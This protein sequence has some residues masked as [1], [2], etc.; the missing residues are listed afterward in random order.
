MNK[1]IIK[2]T[3]IQIVSAIILF[4]CFSESL[5]NAFQEGWLYGSGTSSQSNPSQISTI[6]FYPSLITLIIAT[7]Y[8]FILMKPEYKL[9]LILNVSTLSI[10]VRNTPYRHNIIYIVLIVLLLAGI[11]NTHRFEK[12]EEGNYKDV[13]IDQLMNN[14]LEHEKEIKK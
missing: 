3:I 13:D 11:L 6:L 8:R 5:S 9:F 14:R 2:I 4:W 1:K 12:E 10:L 7:F